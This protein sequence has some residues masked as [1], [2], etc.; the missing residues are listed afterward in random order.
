[1]RRLSLGMSQ[2]ELGD[3]LGVTFQQVQKYEN[4]ANRISASRLQQIANVLNLQ[5]SYFFDEG[6]AGNAK[7]PDSKLQ[8]LVED[9]QSNKDGLALAKAYMA[10]EDKAVRRRIVELVFQVSVAK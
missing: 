3:S 1:M 2:T 4:G 10:I 7:A 6:P 8:T 9:F 5:M